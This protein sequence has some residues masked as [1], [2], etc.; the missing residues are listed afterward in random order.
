MGEIIKRVISSFLIRPFYHTIFTQGNRFILF[1][2]DFPHIKQFKLAHSI[3][4][5]NA[6]SPH[7]MKVYAY[8]LHFLLKVLAT[9]FCK[10]GRDF[11]AAKWESTDAK[12][13]YVISRCLSARERREG[14]SRL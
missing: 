2:I 13:F 4:Q 1:F 5:D 6:A 11:L 12:V 3:L 14:K 7:E 9:Y 10:V 8:Q